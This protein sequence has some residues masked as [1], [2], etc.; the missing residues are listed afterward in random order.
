MTT[1]T[2][3][4]CKKPG[5][6]T[7]GSPSWQCKGPRA[8]KRAGRLGSA[9]ELVLDQAVGLIGEAAGVEDGAVA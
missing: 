6:Y 4:L 8:G 1:G 2:A 7:K 5:D 3:L 9:A